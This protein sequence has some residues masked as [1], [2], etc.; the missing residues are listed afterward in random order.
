MKRI[1][2]ICLLLSFSLSSMAQDAARYTKIQGDEAYEA[3][4]FGQ[5]IRIYES[6]LAEQGGSLPVYYNLGNAYYRDNQLG[7]AMPWVQLGVYIL[8]LIVAVVTLFW[9]N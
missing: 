5:A 8:F 9:Y 1:I 2:Y 3:K 6:V 7:K 4:D